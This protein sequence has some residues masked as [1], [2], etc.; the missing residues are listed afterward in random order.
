MRGSNNGT[1]GL[2]SCLLWSSPECAARVRACVAAR[3]ASSE[4]YACIVEPTVLK[5]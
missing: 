5:R 3:R 2:C 4:L 1:P